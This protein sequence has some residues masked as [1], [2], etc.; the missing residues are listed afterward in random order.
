MWH[1]LSRLRN[2]NRALGERL[3]RNLGDGSCH[4]IRLVVL[5]WTRTPDPALDLRL[6]AL[7]FNLDRTGAFRAL[8]SP[9]PLMR[10]T[11]LVEACL[12][13]R[14][15]G[16]GAWLT[17]DRRAAERRA[18]F[19]IDCVYGGTHRPAPERIHFDAVLALGAASEFV[20]EGPARLQP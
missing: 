16:V 1:M 6:V 14:F 9:G 7:L 19:Y 10:L 13:V 17:L 15:R 12:H 11:I 5:A 20:V 3:L 8:G 2:L 18:L 4:R